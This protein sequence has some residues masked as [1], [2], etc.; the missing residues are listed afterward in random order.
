MSDQTQRLEIATVKAEIGSDILSRFSNDAVAADP[1]PTETGDI[2]NL[3][4]IIFEIESKASVSSSIYPDT[5][6]GLAATAEGGM[7]LVASA[8]IDEIY[9]VWKKE[10]G[11]AVDTGKR[12]LSSQVV[13]D[14]AIS[15][16]ESAQIAE[17]AAALAA[18]A[19]AAIQLS[20]GIFPTTAAGLAATA[21][22]GYFSVP[23]VVADEFLILYRNNSGVAVEED[24][25]PNTKAVRDVS[26]LVQGFSSPAAETE[27][28]VITDPEGGKFGALTTKRLE[29]PFFEAASEAGSTVIG[30]SEGAVVLYADD[31]RTIVG[32]L[33]MQRTAQPGI[34]VTDPEG[35]LLDD[36]SGPGSAGQQ[37]PD[38]FAGGLLFAPVIATAEGIDQTLYLN[39]MLT[40]RDQV[41][42]VTATLAST[43]TTSIQTGDALKVSGPSLGSAAVLNL[44]AKSQPSSRRFMNLSIKHVPMQ[45]VA[46]S[47]KILLLGD[48]ISNRQGGTLLKQFLVAL[49]FTP[50]FIGTMR[51]SAVATD[52][53]DITGELGECREGWETGDY[54]N[55]ITD[56]ALIL[57]PGDEAAY[58]AMSK[59]DQRDRNPFA[60][61]ATGSDPAEI[62]KNGYVFD[63]LFYQGRFS[64]A[65]PDIVIHSLG[66]NDVRDR[67]SATVYDH[68]LSNDTII[69]GQIRAAWPSAKII[70]MLPGTAINSDRNALWTS[71]Y[72]PVIRAI[73]QSAINRAD[74]KLTL[75]PTW[76]MTN[77]EGGYAYTGGTADVDGFFTADWNDAVHPWQASRIGLFKALAPYVA[78]AAINLI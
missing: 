75:A 43:T 63:P 36:L 38:P 17:D 4:Q 45:T 31:E 15:S 30:D 64:L 5:A 73:Q 1:I 76:A 35:G 41:D 16:A 29:T 55:A 23:S 70:R 53:N 20:T 22:G 68:V 32:M 58:L 78:A 52:S 50:V 67:T 61:A 46:N 24:R 57:A 65:T 26:S 28:L 59:T 37:Q 6:T 51:G 19:S 77:P 42:L 13:E 74:P 27:I 12:A 66:T 34:F 62:I 33:E 25:Y 49:G 40:H 39:G 14:A 71:H 48:S 8:E 10:A 47:P 54:T 21:S 9:V 60:R 7:F 11:V 56:R 3:K 18:T 2:Q 72:L 69:N 44:R